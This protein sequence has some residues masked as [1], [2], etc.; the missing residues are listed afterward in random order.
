MRFAHVVLLAALLVCAG[1]LARADVTGLERVPFGGLLRA[2]ADPAGGLLAQRTIDREWGPADDSTYREID[3]PGW[4]S[5][6]WA[7]A[8]SGAV[9]GAGHFYLGEN[10]GWAF[11]LG[12]ATFWFGRWYEQRAA[13]RDWDHLTAFVGDP[14]DSSSTFSF[15]RYAGISGHDPSA[16]ERL[17][18]GDRGAFYRELNDNPDYL[19][20]FV[21]SDALAQQLHVHDL[22][23]AHD[24]SLRRQWLFDAALWANHLLAALDALR[25][26]RAHN[27]PLREQYHLE[28]GQGWRG[29]ER[30]LHAALVRR[31]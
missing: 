21:T 9:P 19:D 27:A 18:N 14:N 25:A 2:D 12:E 20:G 30:E 13:R 1:G 24:A 15:A 26:A 16:L 22:L 28:L 5:E 31:F 29:G 3:V 6:G 7:M 8:L 4:K 17:W 11:A 10:G 23:D